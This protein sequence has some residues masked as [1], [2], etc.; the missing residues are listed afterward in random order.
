MPLHPI[1]EAI[2]IQIDRTSENE[3]S[4]PLYLTSSFCF[5]DAE[6]MRAAFA[7]E[8]D[9]NIY[10]RFSNP[11]VKEFTQRVCALEGAED[12]FATASGMSAVFASFMTFLKKGDHLVSCSSVFGSTHSL[13]TKYLPKYGIDFT[14]VSADRPQEWEAAIRSNTKMLYLETP[15]N[16]GLEIIDLEFAATLTRK[17]ELILNVDNCFATPIGQKPIQYGADLVLHS[18]TKWFDGQGR[19]LG[20]IIVGKKE[21]IHEIYLFCRTTGPA[22]SPF[23]AWVLS[24]SLETLDVRMERH[25]ANALYLAQRLENHSKLS[26]LKYPYLPSHPQHAIAI[27]QMKNGGGIICFELKGGLNSG[28]N[29]LNHLT[30]LSMTANLGDTRSIASHPASTTHAKLTEDE[31]LEVNITP[32]LIRISVGLEFRDDILN[33]ILQTLETC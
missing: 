26:W 15:T 7:D 30:L 8:T 25:A 22:L 12:G 21:L 23:N 6:D 10:S 3:H 2:R 4:S 31:R 24:K 32:G 28:R 9:E 29:F 14:Y 18:A 1:T 33:D 13:I 19:V 17:H 27:K 11:N 16:P 5:D 20:G